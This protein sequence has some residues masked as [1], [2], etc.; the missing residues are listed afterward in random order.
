MSAEP[1]E[2][3]LPLMNEGSAP[4]A[5]AIRAQLKTA[6]RALQAAD[7]P[8]L[9]R[10]NQQNVSRLRNDVEQLEKALADTEGRTLVAALPEAAFSRAAL[11]LETRPDGT[12]VRDDRYPAQ[13]SEHEGCLQFEAYSRALKQLAARLEDP[14]LRPEAQEKV[15]ESY[16][17]LYKEQEAVCDRQVEK[18]QFT[19]TRDSAFATNSFTGALA[20][21]SYSDSDPKKVIKELAKFPLTEP[22]SDSQLKLLRTVSRAVD[23][24][25]DSLERQE[26]SVYLHLL[27]FQHS[28]LQMQAL[29]C[30]PLADKIS[31]VIKTSAA[32]SE[33]RTQC[34]DLLRALTLASPELSTLWRKT[35]LAPDKL[36]E[37]SSTMVA[38][39]SAKTP[40]KSRVAREFETI[41]SETLLE[42]FRA[43]DRV[44]FNEKDPQ[45]M[46]SPEQAALIKSFI[47]HS[48]DQVTGFYLEEMGRFTL[49]RFKSEFEGQIFG[50]T[51]EAVRGLFQFLVKNKYIKK[52]GFKNP[53]NPK[54]GN[55]YSLTTPEY[56]ST[57]FDRNAL[58]AKLAD[59]PLS[60]KQREQVIDRV[61]AFL[62][63][64]RGNPALHL[65]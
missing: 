15:L 31:M 30:T 43:T 59:L 5:K 16:L 10:V 35:A 56:A 58:L 64:E 12:P 42:R 7:I 1:K 25:L 11:V 3:Y 34:E 60:K 37:L 20:L 55:Y 33:K 45:T 13:I 40:G 41:G 27:E 57:K 21:F 28:S 36:Q 14:A 19:P 39:V 44:T 8:G 63:L 2:G 48:P 4:K 17:S 50:M 49:S 54:E 38:P 62:S 29:A 9:S 22:M 53:D 23:S 26:L 61:E 6:S 46:I 52:E 18:V 47:I 24:R 65:P 51:Q 32:F